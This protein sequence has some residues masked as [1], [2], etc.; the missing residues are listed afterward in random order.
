MKARASVESIVWRS[1]EAEREPFNGLSSHRSLGP[2]GPSGDKF[3]PH[4]WR[5]TARPA[6]FATNRDLFSIKDV[7]SKVDTMKL[8]ANSSSRVPRRGSKSRL[9]PGPSPPT[10]IL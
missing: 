10:P 1:I 8:W 9:G 5:Q 6:A 3:D 7:A 4:Y 2:K